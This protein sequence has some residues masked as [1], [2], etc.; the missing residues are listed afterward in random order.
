MCTPIQK[1]ISFYTICLSTECVWVVEK[2]KKFVYL[3]DDCPQNEI[4]MHIKA[5]HHANIHR[6]FFNSSLS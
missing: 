2:A 4:S 5:I 1:L 6:T 3:V